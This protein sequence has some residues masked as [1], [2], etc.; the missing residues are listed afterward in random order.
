M[1]TAAGFTIIEILV[2]IVV[3][4]VLTAIGVVSYRGVQ[5]QAVVAA[6]Q[7]EARGIAEEVEEFKI[8]TQAYPASISNCPTPTAANLC[9]APKADWI[10]SYFAFNTSTANRFPSAVHS[11]TIP[12]YEI[13]LMNNK[14]F[15]YYSTAEITSSNEFVQYVDM[16][17]FIDKFGLRKYQLSFDIKSASTASASTM[18]VYL[19]NGS[20][21]KYDFWV[22][23]PVT[24]EY[25][26][27]TITVTP[28]GPNTNFTQA[29]LAFY[30]TYGTGNR[31]TVK[32]LQIQLAN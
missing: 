21:A 8:E 7:V 24:T 13:S 17:P 16:A 14:Q 22:S 15:Y 25:K 31:A 4:G 3:I 23:V 18:G 28:T 1:S 6:F 26:R 5:E 30:G 12:G 2:V 11:K 20:G 27:Q 9:I 19:Q 32:N 10:R 29:I